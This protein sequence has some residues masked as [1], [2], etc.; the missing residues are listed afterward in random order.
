GEWSQQGAERNRMTFNGEFMGVKFQN[1]RVNNGDKG[2][3]KEG[4]RVKELDQK[5]I[6]N[7]REQLYG[8]WLTTLVPLL[9]KEFRL[10]PLGESRA[11]DKPV[12]GLQVS[13]AGHLDVKLFI[14][15]PRG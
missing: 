12:V 2:W 14:D 3:S 13:R 11:G 5:A 10:K 1:Y 6:N 9:D 7:D 8:E 15:P 4:D